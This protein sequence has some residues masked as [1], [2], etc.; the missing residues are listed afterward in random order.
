MDR[1]GAEVAFAVTAA[2]GGNG[3]SNGFQGFDLAL[4]L[5]KWVLPAFEIEGI[6]VIQ[7]GLRFGQGR[8]VLDQ[9]AVGVFLIQ[10]MGANWVVVAIKEVEHFDEGG[11]ILCYR[12]VGWQFQVAC[13]RLF[14]DITK[15][16]DG[17]RVQAIPLG[18]CKF[19]HGFFGHPV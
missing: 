17:A 1:D 13:V 5:I 2:M 16:T 6:D 19:Q 7:F 18:G 4:L 9:V 15:P 3:K 12:L 10:S 11:F 14:G 8:R